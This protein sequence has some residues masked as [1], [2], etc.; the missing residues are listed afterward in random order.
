MAQKT[1]DRSLVQT[2]V[3]ALLSVLSTPQLVTLFEKLLPHLPALKPA[4]GLYAVLEHE[5]ALDL[6]DA[7]GQAAMYRKRQKVRFLQDHILAFADK[8]WGDGNIFADYQCSPGIPV[9]F[10]RE[11]HRYNILI[12][13]RETKRRGDIE[14]FHIQ[15]KIISGFMRAV[16]EFQTVIDHQTAQLSMSVTYP[17]E[18]RPSQIWL[19]EQ[20]AGRTRVLGPDHVTQLADG[21]QQVTWRSAEPKLHEAYILRWRW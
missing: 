20:N 13:L 19:I 4:V 16:E 1:E 7:M 5:V 2:V 11:G 21:R 3:T 17:V 6:L 9:D 14:T 12:S 10:Y 18:R 15:R 8:V